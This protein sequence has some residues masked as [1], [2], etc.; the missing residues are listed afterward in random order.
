[1]YLKEEKYRRIAHSNFEYLKKLLE[2]LTSEEKGLL[3]ISQ[4]CDVYLQNRFYQFF[5]SDELITTLVVY[6]LKVKSRGASTILDEL[7]P[8]FI[9]KTHTPAAI[10]HIIMSIPRSL[11]WEY[12]TSS[13]GCVITKKRI[14]NGAG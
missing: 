11:N 14:A 12:S 6:M 5:H 4:M 13:S 7:T 8:S 9:T 10:I 2:T 1:M 3:T